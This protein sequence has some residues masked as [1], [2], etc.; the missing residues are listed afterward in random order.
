MKHIIITIGLILF[1]NSLT[2]KPIEHH[3]HSKNVEWAGVEFP[4]LDLRVERYDNSGWVVIY[5]ANNFNFSAENAS[6]MHI[7]G[8]GH[9]HL[10]INDKKISRLYG[11]PYYIKD[12]NIGVNVVKVTLNTNDHSSYVLRGVSIEKKVEVVVSEIPKNISKIDFSEKEWPENV[13]P[14]VKIEV[15]KDKMKGW[16]LHIN[17]ENYSFYEFDSETKVGDYALLSINNVNITKLFGH[18]YHIGMLP[19]EHNIVKV[20]LLGSDNS[21]YTFQDM[22]IMDLQLVMNRSQHNHD[23]HNHG[24]DSHLYVRYNTTIPFEVLFKSKQDLTYILQAS[25]DLKNWSTIQEAKGNGDEIT[26]TDW[27]KAIFQKQYYRVKLV[28]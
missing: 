17:T 28:E 9:A 13:L 15:V 10:Y 23:D 14:K 8:E 11:E 4:T 18:S 20:S 6:S 16:N 24:S 22:A 26:I 5:K 27:R 21:V 1:T 3:D 25:S 12:L 2:G 7:A 19:N